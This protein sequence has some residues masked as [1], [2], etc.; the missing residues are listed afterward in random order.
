VEVLRVRELLVLHVVDVSERHHR[1]DEAMT[2]SMSLS[3]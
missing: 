2:P 1:A 3:M